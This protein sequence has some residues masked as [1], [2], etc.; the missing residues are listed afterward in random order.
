MMKINVRAVSEPYPIPK[1]DCR[2]QRRLSKGIRSQTT[3]EDDLWADASSV[4]ADIPQAN[5]A[6]PQTDEMY[7]PQG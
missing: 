1:W 4:G 3:A 7:F 2:Y 5:K 6:S